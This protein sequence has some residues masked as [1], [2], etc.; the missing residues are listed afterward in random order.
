MHAGNSSTMV[1]LVSIDYST[2]SMTKIIIIIGEFDVVMFSAAVHL[3]LDGEYQIWDGGLPGTYKA[4]YVS[5]TWGSDDHI[6]SEHLIDDQSFPA[7]VS[8]GQR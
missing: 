1:T 3:V 4:V 6:G 5:F 7:E 2:D 8:L